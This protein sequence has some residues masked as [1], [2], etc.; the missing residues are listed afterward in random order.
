[1]T[2]NETELYIG[3]MCGTSIDGVDVALVDFADGQSKLI[4]HYLHPVSK[5]VRDSLIELCD[6]KQTI[7]ENI[8]ANALNTV[9][10]HP[11]PE[12][13]AEVVENRIELLGRMDRQMG[14]VFA[15][16]VNSFLAAQSLSPSQI[17]AIGSHGQTIRHRP[18][19]ETAFSIQIGDPNVI[20]HQTGIKTVS[21]FRRMDLAA[22]GQGAPLAPAFHNA[23]MRSKRE[24]RIILNL[25]GI[26]NITLLPKDPSANVLG[27]DTGT[28][29]TLMDAHFKRFHPKSDEL[30]DRDSQFARS[31]RVNEQ[32]LKVL[33]SDPYF[34]KAPPKSTGREHFSITWLQRQIDSCDFPISAEDI[35]ATLLE[36]SAVTIAD[37]VKNLELDNFEVYASGGGMN[38]PYLLEAIGKH[39]GKKVFQ[40]NDIGVDG[41]YL[42]AMTFAWLA[43]RRVEQLPGNLPSVTGAQSTRILG[44]IYLP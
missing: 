3:L 27:F 25:G 19:R 1:M 30:F 40:T 37:A 35:Q 15:E 14:Y 26:A 43:Y 34:K 42:E 33:L 2:H 12:K 28:A 21:D 4:A 29:N 13:I 20:A 41:D 8:Y 24:N 18:E 38:N 11:V 36:F 22:G 9:S 17:K 23:V 5:E 7:A 31:G 10:G 39:L 32:L 16:A 6:V 44:G